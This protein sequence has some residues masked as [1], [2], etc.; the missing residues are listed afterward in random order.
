MKLLKV[1]GLKISQIALDEEHSLEIQLPFLQRAWKTEF[2]LLPLMVR[3]Q[4]PILLKRLAEALFQ[5]VAE[6]DF[7]LVASSDLSHFYP[8]ETAETYD[9]EM[10]RRIKAFDPDSVLSAEADGSAF[11][12]G[13]GA[14]A[15]MLW[16][17]KLAGADKVQILNYST[18]A[19]A[20]GDPSSVV[21]YG[22]AAV[23]D[24]K[25]YNCS[26]KEFARVAVNVP[27]IRDLFD[28]AIPPGMIG[29]LSVGCL[30]EVPFGKQNVQGVVTELLDRPE[31]PETK[32]IFALLDEFPVLT[33]NQLNLAFS[34]S[35]KY[36][37][38]VAEFFSAMLPPGLSQR[39]D[40]LFKSNLPDGFDIGSLPVISRRIITALIERGPLRGR[41]LDKTFNSIDWRRSARTLVSKGLIVSQP[42]LVRAYC[43]QKIFP[44]GNKL[45]SCPEFRF[46]AC[47]PQ[48]QTIGLI[49][50]KRIR[51]TAAG[52]RERASRSFLD[53]RL[54]RCQFS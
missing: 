46:S 9:G 21:G 22:S 47:I 3:S 20:T 11:A 7:L 35:K 30:V 10:L 48:S 39:S 43:T 12:C 37:Q 44:L 52:Q 54:H 33:E 53:L 1:Q 42:V 40:S 6:K 28:Y 5:V 29:S 34:L 18:S 8:L 2:S 38:P 49:H 27:Q 31:V 51:L 17:S 32:P 16:T 41:Q 23:L 36:L 19:D 15:A 14:V 25:I 13:V 4:D 45:T 26:M 50:P 24:S